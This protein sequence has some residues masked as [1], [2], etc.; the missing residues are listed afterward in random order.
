MKQKIIEVLR[1][2]E[3]E[4]EFDGIAV[5]EKN[6]PAVAKKI[7][8]LLK[9]SDRMPILIVVMAIILLVIFPTDLMRW[10]VGGFIVLL[11]LVLIFNIICTDSDEIDDDEDYFDESNPIIKGQGH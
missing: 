6:Y 2:F 5:N 8:K 3:S 10:I 7:V 4:T 9:V 11:G 1:E